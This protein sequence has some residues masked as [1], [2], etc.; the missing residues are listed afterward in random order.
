MNWKLKQKL[1]GL[2]FILLGVLGI[3]VGGPTGDGTGMI[4]IIALGL[5]SLFS[6]KK[7]ID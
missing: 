5:W 4:V 2:L 3:W 1:T 7:F 6:K